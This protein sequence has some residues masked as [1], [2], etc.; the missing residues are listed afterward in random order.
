VSATLRA[1]PTM[2]RVGL[3]ESVAYRAEMVVW[4]LT[5]TMP[6]VSLALWSSIAAEAPVGRF[7]SE[8]FASYF[9][10]ALVVRQLTSS[11]VVWQ[12]NM[13]I[14]DGAL[15]RRL[16]KP[17]HPMVAYA[18]EN[19][20][21]MPL[22][23]AIC[24]PLVAVAVVFAG[25]GASLP[26]SPLVWAAWLVSLVGAWAIGFAMM[27]LIG[28]LAFVI[29]SSTSVFEVWQLTFAFLSGYLLPLEL[30]P[31]AV[32]AVTDVLPFRYMVAFPVET[33]L[34]MLSPAEVARQLAIQW[35]F[36]AVLGALALWAWR[37]GLRR[38]GAFGG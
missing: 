30:F 35:G 5:M 22:R 27:T 10:A 14:K 1:L 11:W 31:P 24:V 6:L 26:A 3:A 25:A 13:D 23:A 20:G 7:T 33:I 17:V 4:M 32:R 8:T 18:A 36:V 2:L 9:L 34:G 37:L 28:T 12:M 19:V 29:E 21:A 15:S 16:L 38:F